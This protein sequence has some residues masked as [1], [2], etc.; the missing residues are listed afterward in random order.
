MIP[1]T[2]DCV[3]AGHM[4]LVPAHLLQSHSLQCLCAWSATAVHSAGAI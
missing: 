3:V 4:G 2:E 1:T